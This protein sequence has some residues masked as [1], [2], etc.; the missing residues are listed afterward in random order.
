MVC[1]PILLSSALRG[2]AE[3]HKI[4]GQNASTTTSERG[5][6]IGFSGKNT[7]EACGADRWLKPYIISWFRYSQRRFHIPKPGPMG[8]PDVFAQEGAVETCGVSYEDKS[9]SL[10]ID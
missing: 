4:T 6:N 8:V 7:N 5:K 3:E 10:Q 2:L 9:R 1:Y